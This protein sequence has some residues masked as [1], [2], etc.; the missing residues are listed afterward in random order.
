[1]T[2]IK[3]FLSSRSASL[4]FLTIAIISRVI[5]IFYVSYAGRDKM[6]MVLQSKSLLQGK[7]L[8]VPGYYTSNPELVTYDYTPM[9]PHGYPIVLAPFLQLFNYDIYWAT[10]TLDIVACIALIFVVRKLCKQ[11]GFPPIAVNL[12]TLVAGCFEY[13][14]INDSKPTDNVPIVIFLFGISL[15]IKLASS[16]RFS[17]SPI[18]LAS[19]ALFLPSVFRY[20]YPPLSIAVAFSVL[21]IGFIKK[22]KLVKKQG[23]WL[24]GLV[25]L[26]NSCFSFAMKLITGYAGYAVPTARG[27]FPEYLIHWYPIVPGSFVNIPFLTSQAIRI[28]GLSL[29]AIMQCLEV[30]NIITILVLV[31]VFLY[32]FFNK[33]F[34]ATTTPFKW[35]LVT[36]FFASAATFVSLGYLSL[37]YDL[38]RSLTHVWTYVYDH[39]YYVHTVLFIQ[40]LFLGW[41]FLYG[42]TI[43]SWLMKFFVAILS[44]GLFVEITHNIYFHTKVALNFKEYKSEVYREQDY[45][46]FFKLI[47]DLEKKYP[48]HQIWAAAP[49]D[50]Y[51][52]YV[53]TFKGHIGIMDPAALKTNRP[54]LRK[55]TILA[56]ML[57]DHEIPAYNDFLSRSNVLFTH[58][59]AYSNYF[60][61][62]LLP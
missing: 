28:T 34:L 15:V 38:Q 62:E 53:A 44:M 42:T 14:F 47:D 31:I 20:S 12:M 5:N 45:V 54:V 61:I 23:A 35:F 4:A 40:M 8:G 1:M 24:F 33:K 7:G 16:K 56:M 6:F 26:M 55:K 2:K 3:A 21:F 37:T 32:L 39:R 11:I 46:Y 48:E 57:Y 60:I 43:K 52:P 50:D 30:I 22:D 36:G 51:Y 9:W 41:I 58:K 59:I 25:L 18:I 10:T 49:G 29:E 17:W 27:F 13:P 19:F